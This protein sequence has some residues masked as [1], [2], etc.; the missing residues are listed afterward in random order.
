LNAASAEACVRWFASFTTSAASPRT[1]PTG[2]NGAFAI[3]PSRR[4]DRAVVAANA[5]AAG[6]DLRAS[7]LRPSTNRFYR[8]GDAGSRMIDPR[9]GNRGVEFAGRIAEAFKLTSGK[10]VGP[11]SLHTVALTACDG[12]LQAL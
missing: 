2:S 3:A 5:D 10:W 11:A 1:G 12:L 9:D 4:R 8:T 7:P 6:S